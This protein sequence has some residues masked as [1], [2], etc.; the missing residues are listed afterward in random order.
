MVAFSTE[1]LKRICFIIFCQF[2]DVVNS[3]IPLQRLI[4][5]PT[6]LVHFRNFFFIQYQLT[7]VAE[8]INLQAELLA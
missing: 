5:V 2:S 6:S 1:V 8:Q 7:F 3:K 4:F